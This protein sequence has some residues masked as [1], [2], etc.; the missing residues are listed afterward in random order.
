[1]PKT[2]YKLI[3]PQAGRHSEVCDMSILL[4]SDEVLRWKLG[5]RGIWKFCVLDD[6]AYWR[7]L[8]CDYELQEGGKGVR[9]IRIGL[10]TGG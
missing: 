8:E 3:S 9:M 7:S 1:M 5:T 10:N 2:P 4:G 6:T